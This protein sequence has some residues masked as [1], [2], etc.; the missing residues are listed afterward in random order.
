MV[1][2]GVMANVP[3]AGFYVLLADAYPPQLRATGI[4]FGVGVGRAGASLG[5]V[6][7]GYLF[8]QGAS[9]SAVAISMACSSICAALAIW[10]LRQLSASSACSPA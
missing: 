7:A 10:A 5:P 3:A 4:G 8:A 6:L 9:L 2:F 1:L